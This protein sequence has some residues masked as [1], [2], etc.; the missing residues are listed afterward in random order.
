MFL[1]VFS[2]S[3]LS[4]QM[5]LLTHLI[6]QSRNSSNSYLQSFCLTVHFSAI[7][8]TSCTLLNATI[9]FTR[10]NQPLPTFLIYQ[11]TF[12]NTSLESTIDITAR[13]FNAMLSSKDNLTPNTPLSLFLHFARFYPSL[14][15]HR[16]M[17]SE[18]VTLFYAKLPPFSDSL[19]ELAM[20]ASNTIKYS[21]AKKKNILLN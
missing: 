21:C 2:Q 1:N 20:A 19:L 3:S 17:P 13:V 8:K 15:I 11:K 16:R 18:M 9:I 14:L 4:E 6:T 10:I 7:F 12:D 5:P